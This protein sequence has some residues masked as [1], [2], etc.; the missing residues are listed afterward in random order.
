MKT[1]TSLLVAA[2]A[3]LST[4]SAFADDQQLQSRLA[5]QHAQRQIM[6]QPMT[7][8]IYSDHQALESGS[9]MQGS[10]TEPRFELRQN[11]HGQQF[12]VFTLTE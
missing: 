4:G 1:K 7:L 3:A 11:A 5:L 2:V 9:P 8:A 12:G 10:R 6:E